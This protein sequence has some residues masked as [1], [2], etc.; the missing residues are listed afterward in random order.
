MGKAFSP[1]V[2][3]LLMHTT[4]AMSNVSRVG[5]IDGGKTTHLTEGARMMAKEMDQLTK[6]AI[7]AQK[8]GMSYGK[9]MAMKEPVVIKPKPI[10][11]VVG[12]R[13]C[14]NCGKEFMV[15]H[16]RYKVYCSDQCRNEAWN[17]TKRERRKLS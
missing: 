9:Y 15:D 8:A 12:M 3:V 16:N 2:N 11:G 7:A 1:I 17:K 10:P 4:S 14:R 6:D 13:V 5:A